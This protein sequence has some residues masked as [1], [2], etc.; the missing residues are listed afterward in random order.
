VSA[1]CLHKLAQDGFR[2]AKFFSI[3]R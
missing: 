2:P 1:R 3:D